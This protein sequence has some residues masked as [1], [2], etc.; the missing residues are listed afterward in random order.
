MSP[1]NH[2]VIIWPHPKPASPTFSVSALPPPPRP[3]P[4]GPSAGNCGTTFTAHRYHSEPATSRCS[5]LSAPGVRAPCRSRRLCHAS[6]SLAP[7]LLQASPLL[8]IL[9]SL[10]CKPDPWRLPHTHLAS[11]G[12]GVWVPPGHLT[13]RTRTH[14]PAGRLTAGV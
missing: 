5:S 1:W 2:G 7:D 3:N 12:P 4:P 6:C 14:S 10:K 8:S 11:C 9:L 13:S